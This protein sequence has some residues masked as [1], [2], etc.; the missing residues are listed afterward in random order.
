M[1]CV[2][3]VTCSNKREN[4][5]SCWS[6]GEKLISFTTRN[7]KGSDYCYIGDFG[8]IPGWYKTHLTGCIGEILAFYKTLNDQETSYIHRYLMKK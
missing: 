2:I 1:A 6:N 3:S 5:S 7:V 4:L 8:I